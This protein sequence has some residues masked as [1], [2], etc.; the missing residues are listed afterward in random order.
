MFTATQISGAFGLLDTFGSF[1]AAMS[2]AK[3]DR[4]WQAYNNKMVNLQRAQAQGAITTNALIRKEAKQGELMQVQLSERATKASAEVSA[5]ASGTE[6]RS[7]DMVLFDID[8]NAARARATIETNDDYADEATQISRIQTD[9]QAAAQLDTR[10]ISNPNVG[11]LLLGI[12]SNVLKL[13]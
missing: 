2:K 1:G 6:G 11:S 8:R 7:V 3:T 12:G 5:A 13:K 10:T 4:A 9:L